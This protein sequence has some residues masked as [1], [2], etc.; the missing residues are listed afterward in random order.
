M[1][2][3]RYAATA[4]LLA[5]AQSIGGSLYR[6]GPLRPDLLCPLAVFTALYAPPAAAIPAVLALGAARDLASCDPFGTGMVAYGL[7]AVALSIGRRLVDAEHPAGRAL[8]L[9]VGAAASSIALLVGPPLRTLAWIPHPAWIVAGSIAYTV[10][11]CFAVVP[12]LESWRAW[13]GLAGRERPRWS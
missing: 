11:A 8:L 4:L 2:P 7:V 5:A 13:L 3:L 9:L 6:I 10:A 1:R 12:L